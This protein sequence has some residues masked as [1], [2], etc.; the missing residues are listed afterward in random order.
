M[1]MQGAKD[2]AKIVV[3]VIFFQKN[4]ARVARAIEV[5]KPS[6]DSARH[7]VSTEKQFQFWVWGSLGGPSQVGGVGLFY[8]ALG[9]NPM[10]QFF[11]SCFFGN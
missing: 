10:G 6:T 2:I 9:A 5:F 1:T 3:I 8:P 4:V 11:R 7:L